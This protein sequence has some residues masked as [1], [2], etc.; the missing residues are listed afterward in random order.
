MST[1]Q[2]LAENDTTVSVWSWNSQV[3]MAAA[4]T[5]LSRNLDAAEWRLYLGDQPYRKTCADR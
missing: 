2:N 1:D 5:R 4:C 3:I